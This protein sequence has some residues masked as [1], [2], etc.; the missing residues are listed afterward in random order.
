MSKPIQKTLIV[1]LIEELKAK[2]IE[3]YPNFP[4]LTLTHAKASKV[5]D[6]QKDNYHQYNFT[7]TYSF[8][9]DQ[10][11]IILTFCHKGVEVKFEYVGYVDTNPPKPKIIKAVLPQWAA[12]G[13][14]VICKEII[15]INSVGNS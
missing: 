2:K 10:Q 7:G 12:N 6:E 11:P 15:S 13:T 1:Y 5:L 3:N 9:Q 14:I 8:S 4:S